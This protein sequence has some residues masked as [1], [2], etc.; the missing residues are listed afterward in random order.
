MWQYEYVKA[1]ARAHKEC[2][3]CASVEGEKM[4]LQCV[5]KKKVYL[6]RHTV[7]LELLH[8][9]WQSGRRLKI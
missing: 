9:E 2:W 8:K 5:K 3:E 6:L 7:C 1:S 4:T